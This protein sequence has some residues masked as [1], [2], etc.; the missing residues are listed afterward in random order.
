MGIA[1]FIIGLLSLL[2]ACI[3]IVG[4]FV[5]IPAIVAIILGIVD[6]ATMR[7]RGKRKKGMPIA[8]II[9]SVL[10]IIVSI[11]MLLFYCFWGI[12]LLDDYMSD[13]GIYDEIYHQI[14]QG[15]S[16]MIEDN[17][18]IN[19]RDSYMQ[20]RIGEEIKLEGK[21]LK[22]NYVKTYEGKQLVAAK[23]KEYILV[24]VTLTNKSKYERYFSSYDFKIQN[25]DNVSDYEYPHYTGSDIPTLSSQYI[26]ANDSIT[27]DIYFEKKKDSNDYYLIYD[28]YTDH[29]VRIKLELE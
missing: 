21:T 16:D 20:Y 15:I 4:I 29:E 26:K 2:M 14:E 11:I 7:S 24:N 12:E 13:N 6:L 28:M 5:S 1:S 19:D 23:G 27:G 18:L 10:S 3:P 22:V 17:D 9:L 25:K 8:G